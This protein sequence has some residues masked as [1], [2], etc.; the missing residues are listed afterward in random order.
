[1]QHDEAATTQVDLDPPLDIAI[2]AYGRWTV[3]FGIVAVALLV[4]MAVPALRDL[5]KP[6]DEWF[7]E[8]AVNNEYPLLVTGAEALALIG[9]TIAM[10]ILSV[11]GAIVLAQQR[12]WPAFAMWVLVIM[13]TTAVNAA[14]K[15]IYDRPRP[16]MG[17]DEHFTGSFTSGHALTAAV[18][19]L[20]VVLTWVPAGRR[21]RSLLVAGAVYVLIIA[22]S[23]MYLRV[24]WFSDVTAGLAVGAA[25]T[26]A[27]L[28]LASWWRAKP[29]D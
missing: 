25:I 5:V 14:I 1:L 2:R 18:M 20:L 16:P 11:S 28:L 23:R 8:L 24:H 3:L 15:A 10:A 29:V 26:L 17:L 9:G 22:A 27:L 19:M 21:R 13:L 12:R 4:V 7:W 6:L